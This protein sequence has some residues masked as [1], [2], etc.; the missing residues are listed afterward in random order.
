MTYSALVCRYDKNETQ[1][2]CSTSDGKIGAN[3]IW[4]PS[5]VSLI[6][7]ISFSD[8]LISFL[9]LCSIFTLLGQQLIPKCLQYL[10]NK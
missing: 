5:I 3:H 7:S 10:I 6:P 9:L 1:N 2:W 8:V 4:D